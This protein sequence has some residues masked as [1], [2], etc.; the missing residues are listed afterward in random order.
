MPPNTHTLG[1]HWDVNPF[2]PGEFLDKYDTNNRID[3]TFLKNFAVKYKFENVLKVSHSLVSDS[4]FS[5]K[6]FLKIAYVR[7][8]SQRER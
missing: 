8:I 1:D 7:E 5:F 2:M 4:H 3:N 6:C